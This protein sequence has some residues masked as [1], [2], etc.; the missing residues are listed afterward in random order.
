MTKDL[1]TLKASTENPTELEHKPYNKPALTEY[2]TLAKLT[3][4]G[5]GSVGEAGSGTMVACL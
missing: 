4:G 3:Q 2:G 5:G 1:K